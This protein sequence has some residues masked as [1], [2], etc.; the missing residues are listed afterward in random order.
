MSPCLYESNLSYVYLQ[1]NYRITFFSLNVQGTVF[2][3]E[4]KTALKNPVFSFPVFSV[5]PIFFTLGAHLKIFLSMINSNFTNGSFFLCLFCWLL[6]HW[7][8][9]IFSSG[10]CCN[11]ISLIIFLFLIISNA[12]KI[13]IL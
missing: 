7:A 4:S 11:S 9:S 3:L 8:H 1:T 12:S 2:F 10:N 13:I 6:S 5:C